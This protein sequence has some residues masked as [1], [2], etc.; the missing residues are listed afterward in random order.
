MFPSL[1]VVIVLG[2]LTV[3]IQVTYKQQ[4]ALPVI[5]EVRSPMAILSG[6]TAGSSLRILGPEFMPSRKVAVTSTT[7]PILPCSKRI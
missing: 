4:A 3:Q 7:C 1:S 5:P 2:L 6:E